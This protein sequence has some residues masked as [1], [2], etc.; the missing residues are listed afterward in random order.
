MATRKKGGSGDN[1][2]QSRAREQETLTRR[3]SENVEELSERAEEMAARA[4]RPALES[5]HRA[6][7]AI[8]QRPMTSVWTSFGLGVGLGLA[9]VAMLPRER[10]RS[11]DRAARDLAGTLRDLSERAEAL[12]RSASREASG[13]ARD[14]SG[15]AS[16]TARDWGETASR[17]AREAAG[18]LRLF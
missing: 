17:R 4:D 1:G 11:G 12:G 10:L 14:L 13:R 8:Q 16:E 15:R 3:L 7:L 5:E 6:R 2:R 9:V 18:S